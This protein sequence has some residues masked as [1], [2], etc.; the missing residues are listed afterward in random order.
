VSHAIYLS[1]ILFQIAVGKWYINF[2]YEQGQIDCKDDLTAVRN[3]PVIVLGW[4][5]YDALGFLALTIL[6]LQ[7]YEWGAMLYLVKS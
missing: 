2:G 5:T 6:M 1:L 3:K 4:L 7:I